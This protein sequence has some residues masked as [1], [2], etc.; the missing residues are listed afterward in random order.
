[1]EQTHT[2]THMYLM[3]QAAVQQGVG[4]VWS[5]CQMYSSNL[6]NINTRRRSSSPSPFNT[7]TSQPAV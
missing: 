4:M 3:Y 2:H 6:S 1:M 5:L 7:D